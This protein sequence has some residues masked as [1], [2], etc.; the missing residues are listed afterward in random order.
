MSQR[1]RIRE[2]LR[3]H[4]PMTS[5]QVVAVMGED[6]ATVQAQMRQLV[7]RGFLTRDG[8]MYAVT[9]KQVQP[10]WPEVK[11][12]R[13][14]G[15]S[16]DLVREMLRQGDAT[17]T[18]IRIATGLT[19]T[20]ASVALFDMVRLGQVGHDNGPQGKRRYHL[21]RDK[22]VAQTPEERR[23]KRRALQRAYYDR[24]RREAG[25]PKRDEYLAKL[26]EDRRAAVLERRQQAMTRAAQRE[27]AK[28]A[29]EE[30]AA[31]QR[32]A[33]MAKLEAEPVKVQVEAPRPMSVEEW[34]AQGGMVETVAPGAF[35]K[36]REFKRIGVAA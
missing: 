32:A 16:T 4:G 17:S 34:L 12:P 18:E 24:K 25:I 29:K 22:R 2:T 26:A 31:A 19:R 35:G 15:K 13:R 28:R 9:D 7:K 3:T 23:E 1:E 21:L 10:R 20:Q 11:Q 8:S 6:R 27:A 33:L 36:G 14:S 30:Q 5:A